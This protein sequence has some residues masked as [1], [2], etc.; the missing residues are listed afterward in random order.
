[1]LALFS[2]FAFEY[3]PLTELLGVPGAL[4]I[5]CLDLGVLLGAARMISILRRR[6]FPFVRSSNALFIVAA[7]LLLWALQW[8]FL[9]MPLT[10]RLALRFAD[11]GPIVLSPT[12]ADDFTHFSLVT[13]LSDDSARETLRTMY[14]RIRVNSVEV[15]ERHPLAA[16]ID[17]YA[18]KYQVDPAYLFFRSYLNSWYGEAP[19][20]R[21]RFCAR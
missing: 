2:L 3:S 7:G 13:R 1:L 12:A 6:P 21:F 17:K 14:A 18:S 8:M 15:F 10:A 4:M 16:T 9:A 20:V 19:P 5:A 11:S